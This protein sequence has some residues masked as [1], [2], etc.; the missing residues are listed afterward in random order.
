MSDTS[1]N[2]RNFVYFKKQSQI[3]KMTKTSLKR[4]S[5]FGRFD[6]ETSVPFMGKRSKYTKSSPK[7]GLVS[8]IKR[9]LNNH[10]EHKRRIMYGQDAILTCD[11]TNFD[12]LVC[13]DVTPSSYHSLSQGTG[14]GERI[15]NRILVTSAILKIN[16]Q[17]KDD[18]SP[19]QQPLGIRVFV[20]WNKSDPTTNPN[21]LSE[22]FTRLF[23][24]GNTAAGPTNIAYDANLPVNTDK[25][26][27]IYD[28]LF[29]MGQSTGGSAS[30]FSNNDYNIQQTVYVDMSKYIKTLRFDDNNS[31][32]PSNRTLYCWY[33]PV[34]LN[35]GGSALIDNQD[36]KIVANYV[37]DVTFVDI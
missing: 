25:F 11:T 37:S 31:N 8:T 21:Q 35:N 6:A 10:A 26:T 18:P 29:K 30:K 1:D 36:T 20:G 7:K 34:G 27:V 33:L 19:H 9:V 22:K 24:L 4:K 3:F 13:V 5:N 23:E 14:Q 32:Y 15:G 17:L 16:L 12:S 28:K 2:V